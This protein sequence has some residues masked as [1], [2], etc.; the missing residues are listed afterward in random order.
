MDKVKKEE[1]KLQSDLEIQNQHKFGGAIPSPEDKRDWRISDVMMAA[2]PLPEEYKNPAKVPVLNQA[3]IGA[4]VSFSIASTLMFCE[5][6]AGFKAHHDFS[7]GFIYANR[8]PTDYQGEG[9]ITRE[10]LKRLNH[11]G[12]CLYPTFPWNEDYPDVK[13][14][15]EALGE[16]PYKE[17]LPYAIASYFRCYSEREIKEAIMKYGAV[18]FSIT[19]YESFNKDCPVPKPEEKATG[20]HAMCCYGWDKTGWIIR[21]SWSSLWG[22]KGD[23]HIPYEY[24]SKEV[25]GIVINKD[26]PAPKPKNIFKRFFDWCDYY[27]SQGW[28]YVKRFFKKLFL[29]KKK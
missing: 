7:R 1:K 3:A 6:H 23:C 28:Y 15:L 12:D 21:N 2:P 5:H 13:K 22:Y 18:V 10:A 24:P 17:A 11:D 19:T 26:I 27:L 25:W 4:C 9:M 29:K 8:K 16:A 20:G 14:R